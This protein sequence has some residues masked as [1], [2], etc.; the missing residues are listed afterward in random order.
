MNDRDREVVQ[1]ICGLEK[2]GEDVSFSAILT[3]LGDSDRLKLGF[4]LRRLS[5]A[6]FIQRKTDFAPQD[7]ANEAGPFRARYKT[8][9]RTA[10][11]LS[12]SGGS[13]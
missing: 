9:S 12:A 4:Q 2:K 6:G 13:A 5:K 10:D 11:L 1:A 3:V 8:T 7:D